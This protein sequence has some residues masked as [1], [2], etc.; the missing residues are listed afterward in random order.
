[1]ARNRPDI[2]QEKLTRLRELIN[3]AIPDCLVTGYELERAGLVE[4]AAALRTN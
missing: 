4:S 2:T 3:S 1:L